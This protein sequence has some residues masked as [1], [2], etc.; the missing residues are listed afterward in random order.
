MFNAKY[1]LGSNNKPKFEIGIGSPADSNSPLIEHNNFA[2]N[3]NHHNNHHNIHNHSDHHVHFD[4]NARVI[5][6]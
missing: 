6:R 4:R 2:K 3:N 1:V 5:F